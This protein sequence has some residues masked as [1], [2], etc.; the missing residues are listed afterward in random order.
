MAPKL[1]IPDVEGEEQTTI[2]QE[3]AIG[4]EQVENACQVE[5]LKAKNQQ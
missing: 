2:N 1:K 4:L 5:E 3:S